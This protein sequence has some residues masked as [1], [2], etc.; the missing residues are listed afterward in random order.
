[1]LPIIT[2][3]MKSRSQ[4][5]EVLSSI[6]PAPN[7]RLVSLLSELAPRD[8]FLSSRL[9]GVSFIAA[10]HTRFKAITSSPPLQYLKNIPLHK[11]RMLMVN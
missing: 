5:G 2:A 7:R 11:A 3:Q 6:Q 10:F 4:S 1:M 9:P 8:G